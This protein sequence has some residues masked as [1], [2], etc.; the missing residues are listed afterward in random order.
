MKLLLD[1]HTFIWWDS[2]PEKLSQRA[3]ELCR[4]PTNILLLS[5][6]SVWEMQIK[7]QLG[8]LSLK[9]P[10][11]QMIN[12]QQQTNQLELLSITVS[13]V[14][15]LNTLPNIHKDAFDRLLVAQANIENVILIS[16]DLTLAKYPVQINW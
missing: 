7:L 9:L 8:K 4:N 13:H 12:T 6:A 14:L 15:A 16:H 11:A 10:L 5:I 2:E 1:T 3:L